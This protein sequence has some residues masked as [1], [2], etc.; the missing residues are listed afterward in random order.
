M[1]KINSLWIVRI[2]WS[3]ACMHFGK[4]LETVEPGETQMSIGLLFPKI[5]TNKYGKKFFRILQ[6]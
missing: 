4:D 6:N 3:D 2:I 1:R 5:Y